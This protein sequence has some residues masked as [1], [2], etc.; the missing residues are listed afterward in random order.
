M[1][2]RQTP[3]ILIKRIAGFSVIG[4]LNTGIHL[5]TVTSLVELLSANP[6]LANC[7]A[8]VAA[9]IFSFYANS[10]W[11]YGTA[12]TGTRYKRFL[13]VSLVGFAITASLSALANALGWHYLAGTALVFVALP[14]LTFVVHH[15]W[16]WAAE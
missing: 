1:S 14:V 16:T 10:S 13:A 11:N 15:H 7:I 8:F 3:E 9:N 5:L 2:D 4:V 6:V 12:M